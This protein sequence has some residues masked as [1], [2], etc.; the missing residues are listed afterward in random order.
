MIARLH[1]VLLE[2]EY[3]HCIVD[4]QGV[5]YDVQIPLS[6]FDKLPRTGEEVTLWISTQ[7]R[8]DA[9][10]LFGF[11]EKDEKKL[12][13][14]LLDVSGIGGKLALAILSGM[15]LESLCNA[16]V[17][18][19]VKL[20]SKISGVG[21]RTAERLVVDLHDKLPKLG[22]SFAG[23]ASTAAVAQDDPRSEAV[24]DALLALS[25]L[26]F[27]NEQAREK[28]NAIAA[29]LPPEE[30]SSE[31]LLRLAIQQLAGSR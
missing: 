10:T 28:V 30:C 27:K 7:V 15:P 31:N 18:G 25:Q 11:A 6:T 23:S 24:N 14:N 8:E 2:S 17:N 22:M 9:I 29:S 26:G 12:F 21:K 3:T 13:E 4:V 1:G 16:I 5:G 20:L 19:D